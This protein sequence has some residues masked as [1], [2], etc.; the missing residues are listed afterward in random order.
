ML[1]NKF[2]LITEDKEYIYFNKEKIKKE[3]L[4]SN[5][6]QKYIYIYSQKTDFK[7]LSHALRIAQEVQELLKTGFIKFPLDNRDE[8]RNIKSGDAEAQEVIDKVRD[9]LD[10]VDILLLESDLPEN[11]NREVMNKFLLDLLV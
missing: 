5:L 11:S 7:A 2:K 9:I 8:L 10:E 1:D 6:I 4:N 3:K